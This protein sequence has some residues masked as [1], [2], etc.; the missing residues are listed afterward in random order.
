MGH[1]KANKSEVK[2]PAMPSNAE[3]IAAIDRD[4]GGSAAAAKTAPVIAPVKPAAK[5]EKPPEVKAP[6]QPKVEKVAVPKAD[7]EQY[8][9]MRKAIGSVFTSLRKDNGMIALVNHKKDHEEGLKAIAELIGAEKRVYENGYVFYTRTDEASI[10]QSLD[11]YV[12]F[13]VTKLPETPEGIKAVADVIIAA[14]T[15]AGLKATWDGSAKS[16]IHVSK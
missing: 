13:G 11:T 5:A 6:A 16:R 9:T 12:S 7:K 1:R 8:L 14:L 4:I 10:A 3:V 15:A 2:A